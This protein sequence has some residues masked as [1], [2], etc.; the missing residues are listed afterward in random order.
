MTSFR[1]SP[2]SSPP[3]PRRIC[4][5]FPP[6]LRLCQF[7]LHLD[8]RLRAADRTPLYMNA[9]ASAFARFC[10]PGSGSR[11]GSA[12]LTPRTRMR[13]ARLRSRAA[14]PPPRLSSAWP[15]RARLQAPVRARIWRCGRT[16]LATPAR[17]ALDGQHRRRCL[18][19]ERDYCQRIRASHICECAQHGARPEPNTAG[20]TT[21]RAQSRHSVRPCTRPR[22][23]P[24]VRG[25]ERTSARVVRCVAARGDATPAPLTRAARSR[26]AGR[27]EHARALVRTGRVG[28][29]HPRPAVG[30]LIHI[31]ARVRG[32]GYAGHEPAALHPRRPTATRSC[33]GQSSTRAFPP[34]RARVRYPGACSGRPRLTLAPPSPTTY[35]RGLAEDVQRAQSAAAQTRLGAGSRRAR[36]GVRPL[37]T[38]RHPTRRPAHRPRWAGAPQSRRSRSKV[39]LQPIL[40][41]CLSD[42]LPAV[43][44][45]AWC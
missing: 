22:C 39:Q 19:R 29:G 30:E 28:D 40:L 5:L 34:R 24:S 3:L 11:P 2:S 18:G 17:A 14:P 37:C 26:R 31:H 13:R 25:G 8:Q 35:S 44:H 16:R 21:G 33:A 42:N 20:T 1:R 6:A 45:P 10:A 36:L 7:H 41:G 43:R 9:R 15:L 4:F 32:I 12:G 38:R 23:P 27:L